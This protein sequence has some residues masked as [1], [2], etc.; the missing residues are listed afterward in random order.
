MKLKKETDSTLLTLQDIYKYPN[1]K[2]LHK[3]EAHRIFSINL[4]TGDISIY[5]CQYEDDIMPYSFTQLVYLTD[6]KLILR[7]I[8]DITE[9]EIKHCH[10]LNF[11]KYDSMKYEQKNIIIDETIKYERWWVIISKS[12]KDLI[13]YLRIVNVD[14]DNI[15][16]EGKAVYV[17]LN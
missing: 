6:C 1:A 15:E 17:K 14:I 2:I 10:D 13:D 16:S 7:P 3:G 4:Y 9:E 11:W 12:S 5:H 8:S